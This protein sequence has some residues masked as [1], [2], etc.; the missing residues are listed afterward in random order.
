[1]R[2]QRSKGGTDEACRRS[3]FGAFGISGR[4]CADKVV[5]MHVLWSEYEVTD[6]DFEQTA[7]FWSGLIGLEPGRRPVDWESF[8]IWTDTL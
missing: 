7:Y 2:R 3:K 5:L 8:M 4:G 1:M 6:V